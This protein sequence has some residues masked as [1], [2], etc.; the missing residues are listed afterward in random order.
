MDLFNLNLGSG[1]GEAVGTMGTVEAAER[2]HRLAWGTYGEDGAYPFGLL[3]GGMDD[4]TVQVCS[5]SSFTS[6]SSCDVLWA[7]S[8]LVL[9]WS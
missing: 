7:M 2:F 3:A 8:L 6:S 1:D 5:I 4:G 9:R